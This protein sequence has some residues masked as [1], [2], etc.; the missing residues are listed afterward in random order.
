MQKLITKSDQAQ[1]GFYL[2]LIRSF[3]TLKEKPISLGLNWNTQLYTSLDFSNGNFRSGRLWKREEKI[4]A[5][6]LSLATIGATARMQLKHF[7]TFCHLNFRWEVGLKFRFR[8]GVRRELT[9]ARTLQGHQPEMSNSVF[10][11]FSE[12]AKSNDV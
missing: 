8:C 6:I 11:F 2:T 1:A 3:F 9:S 7:A 12:M 10:L 4:A 5:P